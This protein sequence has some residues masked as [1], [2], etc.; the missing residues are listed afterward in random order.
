[1]YLI[2]INLLQIFVPGGG[3]VTTV[4]GRTSED[5]IKD[6]IYNFLCRMFALNSV[7]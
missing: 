4:G 7:N 2:L 5:K 3:L 1:M 6:A